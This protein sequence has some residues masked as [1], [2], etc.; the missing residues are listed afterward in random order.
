MTK[1]NLTVPISWDQITQKQLE[2]YSRSL[3]SSLTATEMKT[4]CLL[5]FSRLKLLKSKPGHEG[6]FMFRKGKVSFSMDADR[7][8][9]LLSRLD[10]LEGNPGLMDPPMIKGRISPDSRLYGLR[11]DQ[12][13]VADQMYTS[14]SKTRREDCL[15]T[16][17]A[18]LYLKN[19]E[20]WNEGQ[21]LETNSIK[22]RAVPIYRRYVVFLWYTGVKLWL[23][24]KYWYVF[25]GS[26]SSDSPADEIVMGLLSSLNEGNV[27]NNAIIKGTEVHEVLYELN[28]KIEHSKT[29]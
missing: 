15:N 24:E 13:L 17:L 5:Q 8:T 21:Q 26:G 6:E 22:F 23:M 10:Y 1:V 12:W 4:L 3:L 29:K 20:R 11:L 2:F 25:S 27:A 9:D 16:M 28:K 18:A 14:F 19:G 7:F